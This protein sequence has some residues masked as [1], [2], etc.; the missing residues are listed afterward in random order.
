MA[1]KKKRTGIDRERMEKLRE[2]L[3]KEGSGEGGGLFF[4]LK[5][6]QT[7]KIRILPIDTEDGWFKRGRMHKFKV[8]GEW[9]AA[10]CTED[11]DCKAC[12]ALGGLAKKKDSTS[13]KKAKMLRPRRRFWSVIFNRNE[14]KVQIWGYSRTVMKDILGYYL[15]PDYDGMFD[16]EAGLDITVERVGSGVKTEYPLR[17][18]RKPSSV[19]E[20]VMEDL[21][22]S[23]DIAKPM[24]EEELEELMDEFMAGAY[25]GDE[26]DDKPRGK[27]GRPEAEEKPKGTKKPADDEDDEDEKPKGTK[28][29]PAP[30]EEPEEKPK[31]GKLPGKKARKEE[32]EDD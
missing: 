12:E 30:E 18:A 14:E 27:T 16:V 11:D 15:D 3:E 19:P 20:E 28:G 2:E 24:D 31:K 7:A 25:E 17:P 9:K 8:G 1:D 21:P 26:D 32:D 13:A 6:G 23:N 10:V 22:D 5:A 4:T 29:R